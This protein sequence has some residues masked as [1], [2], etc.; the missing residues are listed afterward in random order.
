MQNELR[1]RGK[2]A[3]TEQIAHMGK[4]KNV[5]TQIAQ[6][7]QTAHTAHVT[8]TAQSAHI[9]VDTNHSRVAPFLLSFGFLPVSSAST[10][11]LLSLLT[12]QENR[13]KI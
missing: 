4:I 13:H 7:A 5:L 11:L 6:S 1:N 2:T 12:K 9:I 10:V 8:H 3:Q